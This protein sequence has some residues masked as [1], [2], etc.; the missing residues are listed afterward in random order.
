MWKEHLGGQPQLTRTGLLRFQG[1]FVEFVSYD[2]RGLLRQCC[3]N[4]ARN[5]ESVVVRCMQKKIVH[6]CGMVPRMVLDAL[7][8]A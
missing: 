1:C 5:T 3:Y 4:L 7:V 8:E 6:T 2:E